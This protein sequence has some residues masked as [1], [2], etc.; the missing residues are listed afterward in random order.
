MVEK[1]I[2][3]IRYL[4]KHYPYPGE[5]SNARVTKMI[6]LADWEQARRS[7]RQLTPIQ[8]HFDH[9][10]PFVPDVL[11]AAKADPS[12]QVASTV[13]MYGSPKN[14]LSYI[15]S[16][17]PKAGLSADELEVLNKVISDTS[18]LTFRPFIQHVYNTYPI[19][20]ADRYSHLDLV[21]LANE[22]NRKERL[23]SL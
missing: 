17:D 5:L 23:S 16:E 21:S 20:T 9:Y 14:L 12:M 18:S 6:Y 13:N 3:A 7:G 19:R 15:G 4:C 1:L 8:W 22:E 10:G 11:A 2:A